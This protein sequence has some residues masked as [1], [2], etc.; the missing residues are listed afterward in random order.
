M[1]E[2]EP[3]WVPELV[4]EWVQDLASPVAQGALVSC[5]LVVVSCCCCPSVVSLLMLDI[6]ADSSGIG[7]VYSGTDKYS[8]PNLLGNTTPQWLHGNLG[9]APLGHW[10]LIALRAPQLL[11]WVIEPL[12]DLTYHQG[13][14]IS[15][16][17][18]SACLQAPTRASSARP[19]RPLLATVAAAGRPPA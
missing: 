11:L 3:E 5:L 15:L 19:R 2:L 18:F 13:M 4:P 12:R 16:L 14:L 17:M 10:I 1:Q 9:L 7:V 6:M 8:C